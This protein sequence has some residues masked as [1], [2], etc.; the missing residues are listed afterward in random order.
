LKKTTRNIFVRIGYILFIGAFM[1][2]VISAKISRDHEE[3]TDVKVGID[4]TSGNFFITEENVRVALAELL[5]ESG[6]LIQTKDLKKLEA[7]LKEMPQAE[8]SN[9]Y[10][11]NTGQ[12]SIEV[13]QRKPLYRVIRSDGTSY[14]V[15]HQGHKFPCSRKYTARV[16]VV[17]GFIADNGQ[18]TGL[19][20][21]AINR[22]LMEV[23]SA[24]TDEPFWSAQFGQLEVTDKG[25]LQLIPRVGDHVVMLGNSGDLENKLKRLRIFYHEGLEKAGWNTY[26]IINLKYKDQVVCTK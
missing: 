10:V 22:Q 24:F 8:R 14:Y 13:R 3:V 1:T 21:S 23:F 11:N 5:P 4:H 17:T 26:R 6:S 20:S 15:D 16:P 2:L 18:D 19:I 25:E 7:R 9:V 12:L